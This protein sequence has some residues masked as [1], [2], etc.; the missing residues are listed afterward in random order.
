MCNSLCVHPLV[1]LKWFDLGWL[2]SR[3][4]AQLSLLAGQ[5]HNARSGVQR[6]NEPLAWIIWEMC[7]Y[8]YN[9]AL[10]ALFLSWGDIIDSCMY[11]YT[12]YTECSS[13]VVASEFLQCTNCVKVEAILYL[14]V[15]FP[16]PTMCTNRWVW[17]RI[18]V[19]PSDLP[20]GSVQQSP[21]VMH[22]AVQPKLSIHHRSY[23]GE[24]MV[25]AHLY[26]PLCYFL[27][28]ARSVYC[29]HSS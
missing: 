18:H 29:M 22:N 13:V 15:K 9:V 28:A 25:L 24:K 6:N 5:L 11:V 17:T 3:L 20:T 8:T 12:A 21:R 10:C 7:V 2:G 14:M 26:K 16:P 27:E 1:W 4:A 19:W 23:P